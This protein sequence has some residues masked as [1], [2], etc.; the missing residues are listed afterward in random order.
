[1]VT[2]GDEHTLYTKDGDPVKT[3][4]GDDESTAA[5]Y[6]RGPNGQLTLTYPDG[7]VVEFD[8]DGRP[9]KSTDPG[10]VESTYE[11][12]SD[13]SFVVT[14]GDEH[15]LY[16]KDG[17][18]IKSWT[19]DDES[20]AST[21]GPGPNGGHIKTDPD[22]TVTTYTKDGKPVS[23]KD[24]DGTLTEYDEKGRPEKVTDPK[25]NVTTYE[26]TPDGG[27]TI[28]ESNGS[29]THYDKDGHRDYTITSDGKTIDWSVEL[30][31]LWDAYV[32]VGRESTAVREDITKL[33][34]TLSSVGENWRS[35]SGAEFEP[36]R[37]EFDR[38]AG[39]LVGVLDESVKRMKTAYDNYMESETINFKG[40]GG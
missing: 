10:G 30:P 17:E 37:K 31:K 39:D 25:G 12:R 28:T 24:P 40:L 20:N 33:K 21:W 19:G 9:V 32:N 15:T 8:K 11:Y 27:V 34:Q 3:W 4:T 35:P 1:V 36:L 26:Y 7:T 2:T 13:G 38:F 6:G 16:T 23:K 22:G 18:P 5:I 14:T 29:K